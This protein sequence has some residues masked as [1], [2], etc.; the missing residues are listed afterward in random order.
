[1][2]FKDNFYSWANR[3][4]SISNAHAYCFNLVESSG[5]YSI[6]LIGT[7]SFDLQDEDWACDECFE[8]KPRSI[9][10]GRDFDSWQSCL[11]S[12]YDVLEE[13]LCSDEIGAKVLNNSKGIGVGFV[14]GNL[15]IFK[16][17]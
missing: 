5:I 1:M 10:I 17:T 15:E 8:A 13:Y 11:R 2:S 14:D 9:E 4:L 12:M 3:N 6:E 16:K 7:N